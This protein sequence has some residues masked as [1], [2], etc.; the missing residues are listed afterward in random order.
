MAGHGTEGHRRLIF[1]LGFRGQGSGIQGFRGLGF[2]IQGVGVGGSGL[3]RVEGLGVKRRFRGL[4]F[5]ISG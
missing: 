5:S 2:R 1:E 3:Q 4:G